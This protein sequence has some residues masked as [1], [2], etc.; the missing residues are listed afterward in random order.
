MQFLQKANNGQNAFLGGQGE[1]MMDAWLNAEVAKSTYDPV[2]GEGTITSVMKVGGDYKM[3]PPVV[4]ASANWGTAG[5]G[6]NHPVAND[7]AYSTFT[8]AELAVPAPGV[9]GN[10][11]DPDNNDTITVA[12]PRSET[13]AGGDLVLNADGSFTYTPNGTFTGVDSF[14]YHAIDSNE[15]E[16]NTATVTIDVNDPPACSAI[17]DK[18]VCNGTP[19]C[20]WSGSPKNGTCESTVCTPTAD[21]EVGS[22]A[23]GID[24]DCDGVTDCGDTVDCGADPAC[25]Q[26]DC[27]QFLVKDPCN[28]EAT[29]RWDNR[30]KVC[31]AN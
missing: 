8:D 13:L 30:N 1:A 20:Q 12:D 25:Q 21:N 23:D 22:C 6:N 14:T 17:G 7:D 19:G 5:G 27:S 26:V 2:T 4:M 18:S 11:S 31:V 3:V 29:C 16:S 9:L 24:N 15:A 10:D 28:A